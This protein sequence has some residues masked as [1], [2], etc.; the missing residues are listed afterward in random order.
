MI[1]ENVQGKAMMLGVLLFATCSGR[2]PVLA[3]DSAKGEENH[4]EQKAG[5]DLPAQAASIL[6]Q[7]CFRCHRGE[8]S[9]SGRY[10]FNARHVSTMV[11]DSMIVTGK[12]EE[13]EL[14]DAVSK[15]RMPPRN[16]S[17]LPRPSA[18]EVA[19]IR[20]WIEAGAAEFPPPKRRPFMSLETV[21]TRIFEHYQKLD[22]NTNKNIRYFTLANLYNDPGVDE[23]HLRMTRAALAKALNSLSWE[24][25]LVI[26]QAIDPEQVVYAVDISK[27]GWTSEHWLALL[28]EYPYE[29]DAESIVAEG[30]SSGVD[31]LRQ[32]DEV[33]SRLSNDRSLK[34]IR[35]DWFVTI[36]LRPKLYHKLLYELEIPALRDRKD[37]PSKI[38]NPKSMTDRDLEEFL[39][40]DVTSNIFN[41]PPKAKRAA[42]NESGISGQNRMIERHPLG[43][44]GYYWKSY[45][46]LGSNSRA[47]LT[48]FP[49][50]PQRNAKDDFSFIHDGGEI[51]FTLPNRMQGY[52]LATGKGD[53]LDA[54]PIEIVGD[55]LKTSG[56]Q[57]IVSGLSCVVCHRRGMVEPPNDEVR[58]SAGTFG[59][60]GDRIKEL[61]PVAEEMQKLV[62]NDTET[63]SSAVNKLIK[64]YLQA[65]D[66]KDLNIDSLPEPVGEVAFRYLLVPMDLDTVASEL[67]QK[68]QSKL[69]V[70]M[71]ADPRVRQI[72]LGQLRNENG[73]I[74]RDAWQSIQ[75]RSLM[76]QAVDVLGYAP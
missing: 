18:D 40:V 61:Y 63:F 48:E 25:S 33:M 13:S 51:I 50:G 9:S 34:H 55:A 70:L 8:G 10:A 76:Q 62:E 32:I 54:G 73:T 22:V 43:G 11:D 26:P 41:R 47:I 3:E 49:L 69:R 66:D 67:Y 38:N 46:F 6:N 12:P 16:Q 60:I 68:D 28:K 29:I 44:S 27:L 56:N 42:Y 58:L 71:K 14:L 64:P 52:L 7:Y 1:L 53:R 15:G 36:G 72:G 37:D 45:D 4:V 5:A 20:R 24:S 75:G 74:K 30:D 21:M 59:I 39:K 19:V 2:C 57:L 17:G 23:R 65:G 35:A 31:R